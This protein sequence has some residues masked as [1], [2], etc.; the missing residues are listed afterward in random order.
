MIKHIISLG[1]YTGCSSPSLMTQEDEIDSSP[2]KTQVVDDGCSL[3][4]KTKVVDIGCFSLSPM[5]Q[6]GDNNIPG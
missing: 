1:G 2:L 3:P 6:E 5:T 4:M